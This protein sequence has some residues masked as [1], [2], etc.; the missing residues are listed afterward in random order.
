MQPKHKLLVVDDEANIRQ[1]LAE[2]LDDEGYVVQTTG[3]GQEGLRIVE[4]EAPALVLLDVQ[5]S[6]G[7]GLDVLKQIKAQ[8]PEIEVVMISGHATIDRAVEAIKAGAYDFLEK[9]LALKRVLLVVARA[10]ERRKLA[11]DRQA[12]QVQDEERYRIVGDSALMKT[13]MDQIRQVAPTPARVLVTGETGTG[14]ELVA[15]W[16]HRLSPRRDRPYV[17]INCAA[18]PREL[19]ESELFGHEKG[20]FTGA[21]ERKEGKFALADTGT[22]LLDEIGDMDPLLQAKLLRVL[23]TGEF[24]PL[25]TNRQ[26]KV[27]IRVIAATN[28]NLAEKMK[29]GSFRADLYHRLNVFHIHVPALRER[30]DDIPVLAEHFLEAY[31]RDNG[32]PSKRLTDDAREFLR[33]QPFPGNVRELKNLIERAAIVTPG[34]RITKAALL[35]SASRP[36]GGAG[37]LFTRTRPLNEARDELERAFLEAQLVQFGWNISRA[38]AELKVERANLSRRLKQLGLHKPGTAE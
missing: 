30:P 5:L 3:S 10:L 18:I 26:V 35:A 8:H 2:I 13:V 22:V 28:Q 23:E 14:K 12:R 20:A 27:D 4:S 17:K 36:V 21:T 6:D 1:S 29:Q 9:P 33:Q 11:L 32:I 19:L 16:L 31:C 34:D 25:G 24:E 15:F 37:E 7:S 38:A